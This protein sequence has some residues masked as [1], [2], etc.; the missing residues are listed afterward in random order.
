[1]SRKL[2]IAVERLAAAVEQ[3]HARVAD[4]EAAAAGSAVVEG[5]YKAVHKGWGKFAIEGPD[6]P[7]PDYGTM[8]KA[9]AV[10]IA[11]ELNLSS[12]ASA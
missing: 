9:D 3:L 2:E 1:M 7:C 6:G 4:L 10:T 12:G 8:A 11:N 5:K